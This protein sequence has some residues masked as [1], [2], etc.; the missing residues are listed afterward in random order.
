MLDAM[1]E[2][3][4]C[5][6]EGFGCKKDKVRRPPNPYFPAYPRQQQ[7]H[8]KSSLTLLRRTKSGG[9][10]RALL[11]NTTKLGI[12]K[13]HASLPRQISCGRAPPLP[14]PRAYHDQL[15]VLFWITRG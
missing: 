2:A 1:N 3:G 15:A 12:A 11:P 14:M 7:G 8:D 13:H 4:W 10:L 6:L 9:R 5:Y